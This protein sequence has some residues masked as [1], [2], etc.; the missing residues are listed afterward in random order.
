MLKVPIKPMLP[1]LRQ[2]AYANKQPF[3]SK[4]WASI[5]RTYY[6]YIVVATKLN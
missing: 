2:F 5:L 3:N 4:S 6:D 1:I